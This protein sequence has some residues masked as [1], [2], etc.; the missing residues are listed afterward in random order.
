ME[1]VRVKGKEYTPAIVSQTADGKFP[2]LKD[3]EIG[4]DEKL[5]GKPQSTCWD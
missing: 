1:T 3:G 5:I 2:E 4:E